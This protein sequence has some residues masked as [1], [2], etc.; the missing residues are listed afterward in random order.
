MEN[1]KVNLVVGANKALQQD[2]FDLKHKT[3][4]CC[5][6]AMETACNRNDNKARHVRF[7]GD[8]FKVSRHNTFL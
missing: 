1:N 8:G 5:V 6:R 2:E 7:F 3:T 4:C